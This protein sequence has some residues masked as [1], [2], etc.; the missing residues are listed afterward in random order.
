MTSLHLEEWI[1][2]AKDPFV[3]Y[4]RGIAWL[5]LKEWKKARL[6]L[7]YARDMGVAIIVAFHDDHGSV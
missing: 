5:H 7:T 1:R 6:D 2:A 3:H 4:N